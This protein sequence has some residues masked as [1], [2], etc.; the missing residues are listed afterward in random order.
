MP[1]NPNVTLT[2]AYR[3]KYGFGLSWEQELTKDLGLFA[4]LGWDDGH[5]ESW[6]FTAI[7]RLAEVGLV[8]KGKCWC[9]ASDPVGL[10]V[11]AHGRARADREYLA[12][13]GV[14]LIIGAG[15]LRYGPG[16]R[17]DVSYN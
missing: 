15:A 14:D 13:G 5:T 8:L 7:D 11:A 10:A 9:R 4:R 16:A 3:I 1:I 6:A 17:R 2:R 12:A